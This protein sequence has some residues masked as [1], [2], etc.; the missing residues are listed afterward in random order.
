[1]GN[2]LWIPITGFLSVAAVLGLFV[3]LRFRAKQE[4]Q[5]RAKIRERFALMESGACSRSR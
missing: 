3:Y 1:M 4:F 5:R 2:E